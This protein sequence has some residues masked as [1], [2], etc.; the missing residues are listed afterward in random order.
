MPEAR[1]D[2]ATEKT[3]EKSREA[4]RAAQRTPDPVEAERRSFDEA[5]RTGAGATHASLDAARDMAVR[6]AEATRQ[7]AEHGRRTS[8]EIADVWRDAF[9]PLL[10]T[11]FEMNR[12]FDQAWRQTVGFGG[13][14]S[15][16]SARPFAAF[17]PAPLLGLP[18]ADLKETEAAYELSLELP[19]LNRE[20]LELKL[21]GDLI[22]VAASKVESR[23]DAAAAYR[24]SERR[25]G[26]FERSFPLPADVRREAIQAGYADGVLKITL[27]KSGEAE[28]AATRIAVR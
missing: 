14:S 12:W 16:G 26:H 3:L 7:I 21:R 19:G 15:L 10:K 17:N 28:P 5:T 11:Q 8:Y 2:T 27:P 9:G 1:N 23:A 6:G 20:D 18:A 22:T 24:I 13:F 4:T 25:F